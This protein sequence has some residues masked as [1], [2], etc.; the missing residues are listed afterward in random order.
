MLT[1]ISFF[2]STGSGAGRFRTGRAAFSSLTTSLSCKLNAAGWPLLEPEAAPGLWPS[3][4]SEQ[5]RWRKATAEFDFALSPSLG[6]TRNASAVKADDNSSET[7]SHLKPDTMSLLM[8]RSTKIQPQGMNKRLPAEARHRTANESIFAKLSSVASERKSHTCCGEISSE[9]SPDACKL[10]TS[11]AST[12]L[13]GARTHMRS[14]LSMYFKD[15]TMAN[16]GPAQCMDALYP[17]YHGVCRYR[18]SLRS[19]RASN[20]SPSTP[21]T[22]WNSLLRAVPKA[23]DTNWA[24][25]PDDV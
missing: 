23:S 17:K 20:F 19:R 21:N 14:P 22:C 11:T 13:K 2:A 6:S 5:I 10:S 7:K 3:F 1:S 9:G 24:P 25:R 16:S 15:P 8:V 4:K 12:R 18:R